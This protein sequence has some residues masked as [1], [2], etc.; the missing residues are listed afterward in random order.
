MDEPP[1][2]EL[3]ATVYQHGALYECL[4]LLLSLSLIL[5][6]LLYNIVHRINV[7]GVDALEN[8]TGQRGDD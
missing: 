5:L 4:F 3:H 2:F 6:L 8:G 1:R 7:H